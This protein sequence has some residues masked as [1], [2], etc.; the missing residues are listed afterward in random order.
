MKF[1][2]NCRKYLRFK[3]VSLANK[4]DFVRGQ[5]EGKAKVRHLSESIVTSVFLDQRLLTGRGNLV[6]C[7]FNVALCVDVAEAFVLFLK[8]GG[9]LS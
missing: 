5:C 4:C 6:V 8:N 9:F 3:E 1:L 7:E 2:N